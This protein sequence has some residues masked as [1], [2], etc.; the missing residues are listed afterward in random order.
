MNICLVSNGCRQLQRY[1]FWPWLQHFTILQ[2]LNISTKSREGLTDNEILRNRQEKKDRCAPEALMVLFWRQLLKASWI[3]WKTQ[4]VLILFIFL[5]IVLHCIDIQKWL[6]FGA[7]V[8]GGQWGQMFKGRSSNCGGTWT[9]FTDRLTGWDWCIW[10]VWQQREAP[11]PVAQTTLAW[12]CPEQH[13]SSKSKHRG[14]FHKKMDTYTHHGKEHLEE[15][16][17][18]LCCEPNPSQ[19]IRFT[20]VHFKYASK[21]WSTTSPALLLLLFLLLRHAEG[22]PSLSRERSF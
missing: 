5:I 12:S 1:L 6:I 17:P 9:G 2:A 8:S 20:T 4:T 18:M 3:E 10:K 19:T 11:L 22:T 15:I 16:L 13:R 14:A 21:Y 7:V